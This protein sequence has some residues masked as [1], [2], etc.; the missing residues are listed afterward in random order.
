MIYKNS[1][2]CLYSIIRPKAFIFFVCSKRKKL[3]HV[4]LF[5]ALPGKFSRPCIRRLTAVSI[6]LLMAFLI[7]KERIYSV[8]LYTRCPRF[9]LHP[10]N[11]EG[12]P[13]QTADWPPFLGLSF[14]LSSA[15]ESLSFFPPFL[16]PLSVLSAP[17]NES[18]CLY[19]QGRAQLALFLGLAAEKDDGIFPLSRRSRTNR[20]R[21]G[22][23]EKREE[24]KSDHTSSQLCRRRRE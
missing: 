6:L 23:R 21:N 12:S 17:A 10:L 13:F 7:E 18:P 5:I 3:V 8:V 4:I 24:E 2:S 16:V 20:R 22:V 19:S 14:I 9:S 11:G 1:L 15:A